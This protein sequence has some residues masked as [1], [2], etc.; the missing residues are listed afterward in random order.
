MASSMCRASA[1][2]Q[3]NTRSGSTRKSWS[4]T[5]FRSAQ[6]EQQIANNNTN[7]GGSFI[8]EGAQQINVQSLGLYTSVQDIE[9]TVVKTANGAAIRVKDIATVAQGPK[10]RLGPDRSRHSPR[11]WHDR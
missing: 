11:Q 2:R 8:E 7:G 3:R 9:N 6:V 1:G 10:I 4:P 5:D